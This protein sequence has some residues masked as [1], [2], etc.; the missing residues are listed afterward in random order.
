M[1]DRC[2]S[3][4]HLLPDESS[5]RA[6]RAPA[7]FVSLLGDRL[8]GS[9]DTWL[10]WKP[11]ARDL[12]SLTHFRTLVLVKPQGISLSVLRAQGFTQIRSFAVVPNIN[13]ARLF[14]SLRSR[15]A[16]A[17]AW[18][19]YTPFR[20]RARLNK[21]AAKLLTRSGN[22]SRIG[23]ELVL[24]RREASPLEDEL[25]LVVET[26]ELVISIACGTPRPQRKLTIQLATAVGGVLGYAKYADRPETVDLVRQEAHLLERI[27]ALDLET[28]IVP[29]V[30]H[31]GPHGGGYL[32]V[33]TP[34][35][36]RSYAS[37]MSLSPRHSGVLLELAHH[38]GSKRTGDLL[39]QLVRRVD[40]LEEVLDASWR[41]RLLQAV[42][43]ISSRPDV[44]DL[45][46]ALSHGDFAPWN[47]RIDRQTRRLAMLDWEQGKTDQFLLWD[48]FHFRSQVDIFVRRTS[49]ATSV[50]TTL[51]DTLHSE[52]VTDLGLP[53]G[54]VYALYV[55]YLADMCAQWFEARLVPDAGPIIC[56]SKQETR[57][58]MLDIV[59]SSYLPALR[60]T[61]VIG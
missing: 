27:P 50:A 16:A 51:A 39:Q 10:G 3:W 57:G 6:W 22:I 15:R 2:I 49:A 44:K 25:A 56:D 42:A 61:E 21:L 23:D 54:Q 12:P 11:T 58:Q 5:I 7:P 36:P 4:V 40:A 41:A 13:D 8:D 43:A 29:R 26:G 47:L 46:T 9:G 53:A 19:L 38:T 30:L 17:R 28:A 48:S 34:V 33:S 32:M 14:V 37:T 31:H 18:D 55:A 60:G 20:G 52:L 35:A 24:A 59:V 1:D 45:P